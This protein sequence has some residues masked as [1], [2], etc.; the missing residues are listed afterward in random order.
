M[1][2]TVSS[3]YQIVIPK[4]V[5]KNL[6]LAPGD[7]INVSSRDGIASISKVPSVAEQ[8]DTILHASKPK[9]TRAVK[10][11]RQLRDEWGK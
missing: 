4:E 2:V 6:Q 7:K 9:K 1:Q 3:K 8:L 5:R 10:K 11:I